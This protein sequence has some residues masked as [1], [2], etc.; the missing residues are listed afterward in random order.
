LLSPPRLRHQGLDSSYVSL[1]AL[2]GKLR[3][4]GFDGVLRLRRNG[5]GA[6]GRILFCA[7][8]PVLTVLDDA[9]RGWDGVPAERPW[10][11]WISGVAVLAD[12]EESRPRPG[13]LSF[14]RE[15]RNADIS[16]IVDC[17]GPDAAAP[18]L[19]AGDPAYRF[20][21][22][23]VA[24]LPAFFRERDK[25]ARWK[26]LAEWLADVRAARL[27]CD[28]QRPGSQETDFFDL[29][30]FDGEGRVLHLAERVVRGTTAALADF[31][32]RV[33]RAKTARLKT[34][35]V[36]G[37]F[38]VARSFDAETLAAYRAGE[39]GTAAS[40]RWTFGFE[41]SFTGYEGFVRVGPR[42]GFHLLLV[43]E[44]DDG[45]VPVLP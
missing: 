10:E 12:V 3:E 41:E 13:F 32:D 14:R 2:G 8:S 7:G 38:L 40:G 42:R 5:S 36:G 27:H 22:W 23:A 28:L 45:F 37:A 30:T 21:R 31:R 39:P 4:E 15:L 34:G 35:D 18:A 11:E 16:D 24:E 17:A 6:V 9:D 44:T 43:E 1:P 25:T 26:Y 33:V 29:A 20:L 19:L